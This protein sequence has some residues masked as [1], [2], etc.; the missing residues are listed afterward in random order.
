MR[1]EKSQNRTERM[2]I[3]FRLKYRVL[4]KG[5]AGRASAVFR[6][7]WGDVKTGWWGVGMVIFLGRGADLH[8]TCLLLQ[9]IQI[10]FTRLLFWC[11]LTRVVLEKRPLNEC[12]NVVVVVVVVGRR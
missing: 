9:Y 6:V 1:D 4:A 7:E 11:Q 3:R 8:T 5:L 12:R 10:D 2:R